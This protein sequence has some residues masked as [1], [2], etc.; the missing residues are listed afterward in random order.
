M[1][2]HKKVPYKGTVEEVSFQWS[3]DR[4]SSTHPLWERKSYLASPQLARRANSC[5]QAVS[6]QHDPQ[7]RDIIDYSNYPEVLNNN[8]IV[9]IQ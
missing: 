4:I 9:F 6:A 7:R 5:H 8:I 1:L 2:K 3:H